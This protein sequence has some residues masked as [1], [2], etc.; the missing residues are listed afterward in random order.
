VTWVYVIAVGGGDVASRERTES[1]FFG[2]WVLLDM[3]DLSVI[4]LLFT[5]LFSPPSLCCISAIDSAVPPLYL[6]YLLCC[7]SVISLPSLLLLQPLLSIWNY[8]TSTYH[9]FSG[10]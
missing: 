7:I 2:A 6:Y 3:F 9:A 8:L 5:L 4:Y 10:A 1:S